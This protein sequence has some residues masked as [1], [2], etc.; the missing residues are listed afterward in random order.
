MA[1]RRVRHAPIDIRHRR[2]GRVHQ[3]DARHDGGIEMIVDLRR[4]EAGDGDGRKEVVEQRRAGLGQLVQH[5]RAAGD[6]GEDGEQAGAGRR[7]QHAIGRRDGGCG[8]GREAERDRRRELLE[9]PR[10]PRSGAC[11]WGEG[12]R[13]S[14]ASAARR[15]E[16][17]LCGKAPCRI[18]GGTGRSPPRRRRRRSSS[19]RRRRHRR[20]RRR[21]PSRRAGCRRRCGGRVRDRGEEAARPERWRR[22][23]AR[24]M[25]AAERAA[26]ELEGFV[27]KRTSGERE[28]AEPPALSLDPTGSNPSRPTS[29]SLHAAARTRPHWM[30]S[31]HVAWRAKLRGCAP[32][33]RWCRSRRSS[34]G[35]P[36]RAHGRRRRRR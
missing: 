2:E 14:P 29:R 35:S 8:A 5:E 1:K 26:A 4:V 27:M 3:D 12:P 19:P 30:L 25:A 18:C 17:R 10:S 34:R 9:A 24:A 6:L 21:P 7:L 28:R 15:P 20:R 22:T 31:G 36:D 23:Q 33:S 13:S 11:G 16:S 32:A